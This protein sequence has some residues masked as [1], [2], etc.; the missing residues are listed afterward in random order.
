MNGRNPTSMSD[1][2]IIGAG[3]A[4]IGTAI[5]LSQAGIEDFVILERA[6]ASAAPG[7]T[8]PTRV[9]PAT[10][11]RCCTPTR[12]RRTRTGRTPTPGSARSCELHRAHGRPVRP[13][14]LHP[15]RR[16]RHGLTSTRPA[17]TWTA[18]TTGGRT[19][20]GA[21]RR[22]GLRA[23]GQRRLP[24]H[25]RHRHLHGP[26][27]PQRALGPRLRLHRQAGGGHR[28]RRQRRADHPRAG[29]AGR[30]V[31]VFQRTPGWV[32]PRLD[33]RRPRGQ[34]AVRESARRPDS[35]PA[36]LFWGHEVDRDRRWCGTRRSPRSST[37][38]GKAHICARR[39]RIPGCAGSSPPTSARL[40]AHADDQRL[41]PGP[42]TGQLQA[43]HLAHRD[44]RPHG[45]RTAD[46]IEHQ[47]DCIVFATGFDVLQTGPPF[48]IIGL[49]G[50]ALAEEWSGGAQAYKSVSVSGYPNLFFMIGP[51]SGPGHNSALV[52][53]ESQI[54]YAVA[55]HRHDPGAGPALPRRAGGQ[56][57][58]LQPRDCSKRLA[59]TTWIRVQ[60]LVSD[61]R[62]ASTPPCPGLRDPVSS[63][64]AGLPIRRLQAVAR[65]AAVPSGRG[66]RPEILPPDSH[67]KPRGRS[68]RSSAVCVARTARSAGA[69]AT[70]SRAR[71]PSCSMRPSN[72]TV[73]PRPVNTGSRSWPGWR[74]PPPAT[75]ASTATAACCIR[76]CGWAGSSCS[77]TRTS[78][79]CG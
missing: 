31:K 71:C 6:T 70:S 4:G 39:S 61:R 7:A 5:R 9:R 3:F 25:P 55:G 41:L 46:G 37:R 69:P 18:R 28:H 51:N 8:T 49:G 75:S 67:D 78:P 62:T 48:P 29:Q 73:S 13:A 24:G 60:E 76:R 44:D 68:R 58:A 27:D 19:I 38:L 74:A 59:K 47:V 2:L 12:S 79:G 22:A 52:Y 14:P 36:G 32:L 77:T 35:R 34:G 64:D 50:R 43:H 45:I 16:Q 40:Q 42:A 21:H 30:S 56:P 17:G 20:Q 54:D 66:R 26:Q 23:A 72:R 10:S 63:S 1:T 57:G 11:P 53:M 15:V 65:D 33:S